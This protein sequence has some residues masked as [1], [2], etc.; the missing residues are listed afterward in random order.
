MR[1]LLN[2]TLILLALCGLIV[3]PAIAS[4]LVDVRRADLASASADYVSAAAQYEHTAR[5]L[6]WRTDLWERAGHAAFL[7]KEDQETIRL[8]TH[9]R[10]LTVEGWGDLGEAYFQLNEIDLAIASLEKGVRDAGASARIYRLLALAYNQKGDL[11]SETTA[12]GN[13]LAMQP[14]DSAAHYRLGVLLSLTDSDQSIRE[15][16]MAAKQNAA[17]DPAYQT[18]RTTLNLASLETDKAQSLIVIGRG[19]GLVEEWPLARE[20]F[21]RAIDADEKNAE[22]WAWLGEAN[23][24]TGQDGHEQLV[25]AETLDPFSANVRALFGLYWKRN[26]QPTLALAEYQWAA[27]LEPQN[28]YWQAALGEAHAQIGDLPPALEAY[29]HATDL[30]PADAAFWRLLAIFCAHYNYQTAEAGLPAAHQVVALAP[31]EAA[32]YDLLGWLYLSSGLLNEA[33]TT[34]EHAVEMDPALASAHVHLAMLYLQRGDPSMARAQLILARDIDPTSADGQ[35]AT[36]ML[37]QYLP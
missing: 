25:R 20:A 12:L 2:R 23:Q 26:E 8:L 21:Q 3:V 18:M 28:P 19:L 14:D 6:F 7:A 11:R 29:Q 15:L 1:A 16:S 5:L 32:S 17:Y 35:L 33:E 9:A 10:T 24:H 30:A 22:A 34:L 4:S 36:Q 37:S 27:I 31:D 13:Y